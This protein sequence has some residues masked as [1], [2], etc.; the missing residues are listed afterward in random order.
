MRGN[1]FQF[2]AFFR[3]GYM[4]ERPKRKG[5]QVDIGQVPELQLERS[6]SY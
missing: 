2:D 3:E 6:I 5:H 1:Y 4:K